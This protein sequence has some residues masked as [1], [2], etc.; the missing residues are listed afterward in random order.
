MYRIVKVLNNNGIL[1]LEGES[2]REIILLGNG[3]GFG[4]RT[5]ERLEHVKEA[6]RYELVV[7]NLRLFSRSTALTL[8]ISRRQGIS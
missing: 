5:G 2:R 8:Y 6:K 3:I 7:K 4:R 1:A